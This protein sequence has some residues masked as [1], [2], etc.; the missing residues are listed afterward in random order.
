MDLYDVIT[1]E[2]HRGAIGRT[3]S[4]IGYHRP[5]LDRSLAGVMRAFWL[6]P[7]V[8]EMIET[9]KDT[10]RGVVESLFR[11]S[12][13]FDT[14]RLPVE[15]ARWRAEAVVSALPEEDAKYY[16]SLSA[17][18]FH[19]DKQRML[20]GEP[21]VSLG[22]HDFSENPDSLFDAGIII[23]GPDLA[24]CFWTDAID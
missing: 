24:F 3:G 23:I 8:D 6:K 1:Y 12:M 17:R 19:D 10:I 13:L 9:D 5:T 20:R 2:Y 18:D 16:I 7:M 14:E 15:E 22:Y 4:Q 21:E 11:W